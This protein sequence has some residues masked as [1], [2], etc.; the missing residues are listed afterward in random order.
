MPQP[1]HQAI[2]FQVQRARVIELQQ[3]RRLGIRLRVWG[4]IEFVTSSHCECEGFVGTHFLSTRS[5]SRHVTRLQGGFQLRVE[6]VVQSVA[7]LAREDSR[8]VTEDDIAAIKAEKSGF[9]SWI[10]G[11]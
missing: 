5:S 4:S 2:C 9:G 6:R 10:L 7:V 3:R 1:V 11:Q 8:R